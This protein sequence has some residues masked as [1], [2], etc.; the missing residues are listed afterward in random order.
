VRSQALSSELHEVT[1]QVSLSVGQLGSPQLLPTLLR[2]VVRAI[3]C[4]KFAPINRC[5]NEV[6]QVKTSVIVVQHNWEIRE[7]NWVSL[8]APV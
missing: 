5:G 3:L 7:F 6:V 8:P 4:K 1:L 2:C